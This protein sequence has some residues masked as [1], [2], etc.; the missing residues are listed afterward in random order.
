MK[1]FSALMGWILLCFAVAGLG[2][3]ASTNAPEFYSQLTLPS[4]SPPAWVFGPVWMALYLMMA[5]AAWLVWRERGLRGA[6]VELTLFIVQLAANA[7]WS[8]LFF[9]WRQGLWSS[10]D[11]VLLWA[12]LATTVVFFWRVRP[13][14]GILLLP[15]LA[16]I[17][18]AAVLNILVW[19]LN[20]GML[21]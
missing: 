18:F 10:V 6:K 19:R 21:S 13:L 8:W 14:A 16:W 2:A 5:I 12:L 3:V 11:I 7:L 9:A 20:P 17:S 15:Y 1:N 4:F